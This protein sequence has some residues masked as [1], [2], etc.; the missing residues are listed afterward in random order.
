MHRLLTLAIIAI[1]MVGMTTGFGSNTFFINLQKL[2][3]SEEVIESPITQ[4]T[5]DLEV[6]RVL[7]D[8]DGIQNNG[9]EFF[10]NKI[11]KCSFHTPDGLGA[12]SIIVCKLTDGNDKAI[13][14]GRLVL[15][16]ELLPSATVFIPINQN[17]FDN[18]NDVQK[19]HDVKIVVLG[20]NPIYIGD[21]IDND[22]DGLVDEDPVDGI[23][24]DGDGVVD[25]DP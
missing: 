6:E 16:T 19:I 2:G 4:A 9:D 15:Q 5:V 14:E 7:V 25:E 24:N 20:P 22:G 17:A 10:A 8:P 3:V 21:Q 18:S 23:D 12:G 11:T 13:A 1:A